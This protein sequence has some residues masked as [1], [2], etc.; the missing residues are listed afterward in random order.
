MGAVRPW[1]L[2]PVVSMGGALGTGAHLRV[3]V[4]QATTVIDVIKVNSAFLFSVSLVLG[5]Y[6][7]QYRNF[8]YLQV[9]IVEVI[10]HCIM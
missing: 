1:D 6:I 8:S 7:L 4:C 9:M 10:L 2:P 3:T 5:C